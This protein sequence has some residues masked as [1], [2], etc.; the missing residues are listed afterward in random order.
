M[1]VKT[2]GLKAFKKAVSYN[3]DLADQV[4]DMLRKSTN[5]EVISP[6]TLAIINFRYNPIGN[7]Y[8]EKELDAL[9][10]FISK[11]IVESREA[12][13]VTTVLQ[14]QVVLRMCLIN[15]RTTLKDIN[16]TLAMGEKVVKEYN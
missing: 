4:E 6:A 8:T 1:S 3:V 15:P 12:L 9:N 14:N 5:W 11:K 10:Q 13:L 16:E 7:T 2:F